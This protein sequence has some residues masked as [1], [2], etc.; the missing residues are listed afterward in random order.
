MVRECALANS[1]ILWNEP[2]LRQLRIDISPERL[3]VSRAITTNAPIVRQNPTPSYQEYFAPQLAR[4]EDRDE[5]RDAQTAIHDS[6]N[7]KWTWSG[8]LSLVFSLLWWVLELL[9]MKQ[10]TQDQA[11]KVS[12]LQAV[13]ACPNLW[14]NTPNQLEVARKS[15][16]R[17]MRLFHCCGVRTAEPLVVALV[18]TSADRGILRLYQALERHPCSTYRSWLSSRMRS[19]VNVHTYR[20]RNWERE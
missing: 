11:G 8:W 13:L 1:K 5:S 16:V 19:R 15:P 14:S 9:P 17:R 6:L 18:S 12:L 20:V 4:F 3:K 2:R 7:P 10:W